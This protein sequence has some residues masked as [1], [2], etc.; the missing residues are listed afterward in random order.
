MCR[1]H[2]LA[3]A[4]L[5]TETE[6]VY[7]LGNGTGYSVREVIDTV[8]KVSGRDFKVTETSRRA[9]DPA[10]LTADATK[11]KTQLG[12][13][14]QLGELETIIETAWRW[15]NEHPQGYTD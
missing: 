11:A 3:L 2:L 9:G 7:N 8:R 15:H 10:I 4:Q 12:W 1:A 14:P 5:E 6:L 13:S